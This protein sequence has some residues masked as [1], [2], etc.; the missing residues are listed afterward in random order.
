MRHSAKTIE[1]YIKLHSK[2]VQR[3]LKTMRVTIKKA[4]PKATQKISYGIPTFYLHRNLVHFAA[5]KKHVGF[6]PGS[7]GVKA[8]K[9]ELSTFKTAKGSIQFPLDK[10]LPTGLITKIVRFRVKETLKKMKIK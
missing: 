8:F 9:K 3:L 7:S 6:Y 2:D 1:S 10:P 5:F 4:A